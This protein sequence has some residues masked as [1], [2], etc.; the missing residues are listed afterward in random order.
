MTITAT[1]V[2]SWERRDREDMMPSIC[3]AADGDLFAR[4]VRLAPAHP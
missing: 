2:T 1:I 3:R 4:F